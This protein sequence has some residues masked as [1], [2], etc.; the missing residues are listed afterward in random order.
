METATKNLVNDH[1]YILRLMDVMEKMVINISTNIEH[2]E[3]VANLINNYAGE[4]HQTKEEK[5]LFPLMLKKAFAN[6][7][8]PIAEMLLEHDTSRAFVK[9][10]ME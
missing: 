1:V 7:E 10:V 4:F 6:E 2:I 5:L 3:M 9:N 8:G